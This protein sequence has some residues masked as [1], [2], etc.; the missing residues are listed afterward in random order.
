MPNS[1]FDAG[2]QS[3][4]SQ[5]RAGQGTLFPSPEDWRDAPIYFL[6]MDRFNRPDAPPRNLPFDASFNKF[7]GGTFEGVRSKLEYI[8]DLGFGA[9]WLSPVL[10]NP[11]F[12]NT[13]YHG[14]GIQ[15]FL[16]V[17][18][19]FASAPGQEEIELRRL[20]DDAHRTG[21][22]IIF[23]I[24]LHHAGNVFEYAVP[25]N[26]GV[27]EADSIDWTNS[28]QPIRWRDATGKGDPSLTDAPP[29]PP[30][31]AAVWPSELRHNS[32]F[33]RQ[34][35]SQSPG[36][37]PAGD[38]DSLK[39]ISFNF[40]GTGLNAAQD[41]LIRAY[42]YIIA[43]FD[44]DGFRID[45]LKFIP[46]DFERIFGNAMREFGMSAGKKN[47]F[48][49]GEVFDDESTIAQFIGR[50]TTA[51][52]QAV[53]V[54]AALDY[55]LFFK[56]P[57]MVKGLGPTPADVANVFEN[58][59]RVEA[60]IITSHGEAGQYFVTFLDNHDQPQ[61]F[62]YT[63][64]TQLADQI[65]LGLGLLFGLPGIPC[66]YYGTEQG[67][68]GHKTAQNTDDSMVREALW[69]K[70]GA[71]GQS[72]G[73]DTSHPLYV[74]LRSL[75]QVRSDQPALRYGRYYFRP[76]SGDG[77]NFGLSAFPTGVL[78]FSRILNDQEV[79]VIG[80]T[81]PQGSFAGE[82]I[83]DA[84]INGAN[85]TY[86]V[87]FSNKG[88]TGTTAGPVRLKSAGSVSIHEV[89]GSTTNGPVRT[90]SVNLDPQEIQILAV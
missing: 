27:T 86:R 1:I 60:D 50:N 44:V 70:M 56:F 51:T 26:G 74:A 8:K 69:G 31:D 76:L 4:L 5:A 79:I 82:V 32:L 15:N 29:N 62:G 43:K 52:G 28:V 21:L 11:Q 75:G 12:D 38:F 89:D 40:P 67:L 34:G 36:G 19:R 37:Q 7:Q 23:D 58:R 84:K 48:T 73:F 17:E 90:L 13:A 18:P 68:T 64:P 72:L 66:V 78:A 87:L 80:N 57:L 85:P 42:Q 16:A 65:V 81:I 30:L 33:T 46:P 45:T 83:V 71:T 47:F 55:P 77:T 35:N 3:V 14:Y 6:M 24:V 39:G 22:Y 41:I 53:G 10:K 2:V 88:K 49:Y 61:R 63:G 9:I 59:K 20:V 25:S 54:D